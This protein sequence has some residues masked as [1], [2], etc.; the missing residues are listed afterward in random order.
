MKKMN[1]SCFLI[2][3]VLVCELYS[4]NK[5]GDNSSL[6]RGNGRPVSVLLEE[7]KCLFIT[8]P[9]CGSLTF[10]KWGF[11]IS[12]LAQDYGININERVSYKNKD[13]FQ[14]HPFLK[15]SFFKDFGFNTSW[16][17]IFHNPNCRINLQ[18]RNFSDYLFNLEYKKYMIIRDVYKRLISFYVQHYE[19]FKS[20][21]VLKGFIR[22]NEEYS[23]KD[24]ITFIC[25]KKWLNEHVNPYSLML[26][27]TIKDNIDLFD[28]VDFDFLVSRMAEICQEHDL[29]FLISDIPNQHKNM[30]FGDSFYDKI[31]SIPKPLWNKGK[32]RRDRE[33]WFDEDMKQ[34]IADHYAED[35]ILFESYLKKI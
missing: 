1:F 27:K 31:Y 4:G 15:R 11:Q 30:Q 14:Y 18:N 6:F 20:I 12:G 17:E 28:I 29:T 7:E 35:F 24:L 32:P 21:F 13:I 16:H 19:V 2:L 8:F 9:K 10:I 23:F 25:K 33:D 5:K 26:G 3:L 22:S 34:M